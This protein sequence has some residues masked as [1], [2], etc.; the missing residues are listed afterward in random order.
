MNLRFKMEYLKRIYLRYHRAKKN[1][2]KKILDEFCNT[3][4]YNRKYA[5]W[6]INQPLKSKDYKI[7]RSKDFIYTKETL[8]V[9]ET[10]WKSS[11][12][13]WSRRLKAAL[14]SW[15]PYA[16]NDSIYRPELKNNPDILKLT[17]SHT[18]DLR[19]KATLSTRST[20][21]TFTPNGRRQERL[22]AKVKPLH[23]KPLRILKMLY[24]S[25]LKPLTLITM[26]LSLIIIS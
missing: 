5:I 23:S 1:E 26:A 2:K 16:K 15:L 8:S 21:Q 24:L 11:G 19:N 12:Y 18:A 22:W 4:N 20:A 9:I 3:C 17:S 25:I 13:L 7:R 6:L 10:I 14:P